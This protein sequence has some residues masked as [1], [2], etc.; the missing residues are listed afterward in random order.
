LDVGAFNCCFSFECE[1]RGVVEVVAID[2]QSPEEVGFF[3]LRD[4]VGSHRVHFQ[5]GSQS[6]STQK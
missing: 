4:L 6:L 5:Q 3:M 2:L 1:R